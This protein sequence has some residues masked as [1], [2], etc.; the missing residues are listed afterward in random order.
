MRNMPSEMAT[1]PLRRLTRNSFKAGNPSFERIKFHCR[2]ERGFETL[3]MLISKAES[4]KIFVTRYSIIRK[5]CRRRHEFR[6]KIEASIRMKPLKP[7][8][9]GVGSF[10]LK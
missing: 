2:Y 6:L 9:D 10:V 1:S 7:L 3:D 8:L 4:V 5:D